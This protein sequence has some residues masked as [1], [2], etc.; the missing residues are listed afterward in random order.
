[1]KEFKGFKS[2]LDILKSIYEYILYDTFEFIDNM[3]EFKGFKSILD[4][5]KS[6]WVNMKGTKELKE[7][8]DINPF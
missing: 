1:M 4:I 7:K 6:I 8:Y 5:L 3:K 2:I